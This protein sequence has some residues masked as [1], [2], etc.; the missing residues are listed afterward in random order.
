MVFT[1]IFY[2]T[3]SVSALYAASTLAAVTAFTSV[4]Q[5]TATSPAY[6]T[7]GAHVCLILLLASPCARPR[8]CWRS[9]IR[10]RSRWL[11]FKTLLNLADPFSACAGATDAQ[12]S[13]DVA[14]SPPK[15]Y[16]KMAANNFYYYAPPHV[17]SLDPWLGPVSGGEIV[18]RVC[19]S[20]PACSLCILSVF[21]D[22]L[23]GCDHCHLLALILLL[24]GCMRVAQ[25]RW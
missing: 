12:I 2:N 15:F 22:G 24:C 23:L 18:S 3:G 10:L 17:T 13:V 14:S 6:A 7:A 25:A 16:A 5:V 19:F 20:L 11:F 21:V 8:C 1:G 4:T 9:R